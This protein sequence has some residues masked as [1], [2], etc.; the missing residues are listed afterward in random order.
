MLLANT[1]TPVPSVV[2]V[3][4]INGLAVVLQQTPRA[5]T[6]EPPSE[7]IFPPLN[8]EVLVIDVAATVVNVGELPVG[9]VGLEFS[10][11]NSFW[12]LKKKT[13]SK[14]IK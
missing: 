13:D 2:W 7:L 1:P 11:L 8:A 4:V 10:A 6:A 12:Q 3:P 9:L 14:N 5:V